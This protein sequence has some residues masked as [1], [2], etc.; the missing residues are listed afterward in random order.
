MESLENDIEDL[1]ELKEKME[2]KCFRQ[3]EKLV[4]TDENLSDYQR[5]IATLG[6]EELK[7]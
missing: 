6:T 3:R 5:D 4:L 1:K 2:N 7:E